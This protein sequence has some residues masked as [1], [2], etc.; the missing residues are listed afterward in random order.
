[1][2]SFPYV[3]II[4]VLVGLT[5]IGCVQPPEIAETN[6]A[7]IEVQ[8]QVTAKPTDLTPKAKNDLEI[9]VYKSPTCGCCTSWESHLTDAGFKVTS[10]STDKM[11]EIKKQHKVP[12]S[13]GSCHTALVG[14]YVIEGHVPADDI[15]KLLA[16]RPKVLGL[17]VPGMPQH[18]PGMQP[19]GEK[20]SGFDVLSFDET[21]KTAVFTSY[22]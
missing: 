9:T 2:K 1:M 3:V 16:Q 18:S 15:D 14:G 10:N 5:F 20:P 13:L 17:A 12:Q 19:K 22:K 11:T 7:P 21:G 8:K 4:L 6:T